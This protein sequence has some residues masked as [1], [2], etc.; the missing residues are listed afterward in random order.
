M[1]LALIVGTKYLTKYIM[2]HF[3]TQV[4]IID[5]K[6]NNKI[7][8]ISKKKYLKKNNNLIKIILI[9]LIQKASK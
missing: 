6:N 3:I 4:R 7:L 9:K 5:F 1:L 8:K 2:L